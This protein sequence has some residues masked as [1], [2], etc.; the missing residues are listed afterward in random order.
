[1][2]HTR[3]E[4]LRF[5]GCPYD[6]RILTNTQFLERAA[7]IVTRVPTVHHEKDGSVTFSPPSARSRRST[8][9][10][11]MA[12]A[13]MA[14]FAFSGSAGASPLDTSGT[15]SPWIQSD[16]ADYAPGATVTL[17]GGSWQPGE[18][19]HIFVN[20]DEGQTWSRNVDVTA[21]GDGG[22][23]D[24][25]AL[26][27]S[28]VAVYTVTA[29]G[30]TSGT[31][32]TSFTDG[33]VKFDIAPTGATAQFVE[34]LY[35]ASGTC[36]G[37]VKSGFPK[38]LN[39]SNGDNVGVGNNE[40]IRLDAAATSDQ[41]GAFS[42]WSSTDS[43]ASAFTVIAGT[44][45]RSICIPGFQ[46]GTRNYRATYAP[47]NT[48]P[49]AAPQS[50]STAEDTAKPI[51]LSASDVDGNSTSFAIVSGPSHGTLGTIASPA[52]TGTAPRTCNAVVTYTPAADYN[53]PD[54]FTFKANDGTVDSAAATV[55]ITV[56][57]VN[58]APTATPQSVSTAEDT[59]KPITLS[60][61]DV[62]G[63]FRL[64][65][66]SFPG[67]VTAR[68]ARSASPDLYGYGTRTCNA[69]ALTYTP[70]ADYNGPDSFTF[71]A[72]RR[73]GRLGRGDESASP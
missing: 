31:A 70:A 54:S 25:F 47:P 62:D 9:W 3:G 35:A 24:A 43:P 39:G 36:G 7:G 1:M 56:T 10:A 8:F 32:T 67:R 23:T 21:N 73:H 17:T 37:A 42:A 72:E 26:P 55:S 58:D 69:V 11:V 41:G 16:Q 51:T 66:R 60:A 65:S 27:T 5:P 6:G 63:N 44:G 19:V 68:W 28:F 33:N 2:L 50:V 64:R 52:C 71:K 61:S 12:L 45:G 4:E 29:T 53:G 15:A 30:S 59:A 18:S 38:T 46:S 13:V 48:A 22:I 14:I 20:D 34:T 40:S 49:S 57:P